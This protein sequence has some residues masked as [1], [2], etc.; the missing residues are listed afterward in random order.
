MQNRKFGIEIECGFDRELS[1]RDRGVAWANSISL[2]R[3]AASAGKISTYWA[4]NAGHDGT[5]LETRSPILC[6]AA[7]FKELHTV[8]NLLRENGGYVTSR[9]GMHIHHDA[10]EFVNDAE[11]VSRLVSSWR[12]NEEVIYRL[13]ADRRHGSPVCPRWTDKLETDIKKFGT[14]GKITRKDSYYD[15]TVTIDDFKS[16][17]WDRRDLNINA[18]G[19]HGTI[20]IRLHQGTLDPVQAEAWIR[21]GQAFLNKIASVKRPLKKVEDVD[22]LFDLVRATRYTKKNRHLLGNPDHDAVVA[23]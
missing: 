13:V 6:G 12:A 4:D 8:M 14:D 11:A 19:E 21:F 1:R 7:G 15:T 18:L 9:D 16:W 22:N 17:G 10:P 20:E 5:L 3:S 2:L 23:A